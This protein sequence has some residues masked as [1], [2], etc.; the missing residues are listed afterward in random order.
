M[1]QSYAGNL[2]MREARDLY[3]KDNGF[4]PDGGYNASW[5]ELKLGPIPL[6]FPNSPA[7]KRAVPFHDLHHLVTGYGTDWVGEAEI[8]AWEVGAG[9]GPMLVAWQL[10]LSMMLVGTFIAPRRTFAAFSRGRRSRSFYR[11]SYPSLIA[12]T[13]AEA[14]ARAALPVAP[15]ARP[16][17]A[18]LYAASLAGGLVA[19]AVTAALFVPLAPLGVIAGLIARR[20]STAGSQALT[21]KV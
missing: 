6:P 17:D 2:S 1:T 10:N 21:S 9:C 14:K 16:A 7:R 19:F 3:F 8:S 15:S 5:V 13:V 18:A 4:A 20:R 11:D 12:S